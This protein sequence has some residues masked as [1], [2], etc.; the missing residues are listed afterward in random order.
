M[1][2]YYDA[3][4]RPPDEVI[5]EALGYLFER[6]GTWDITQAGQI[7][8]ETKGQWE[9]A[10]DAL[11]RLSRDLADCRSAKDGSHRDV[12]ALNDEVRRLREQL[13]TTIKMK[14]EWGA[15][16]GA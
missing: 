14:G 11:D 7:A 13:R 1:S 9:D 6:A 15:P 10:L 2:G 12:A 8:I 4:T 16:W 3:S 5:R